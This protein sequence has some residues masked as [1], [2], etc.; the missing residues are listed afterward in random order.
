M[1]SSAITQRHADSCNP[2]K[3]DA[4]CRLALPLLCIQKD[5][6]SVESAFPVVTSTTPTLTANDIV[7]D[8]W[9]AGNVA[10]TVPVAGFV[11][12]SLALANARCEKEVGPGWRMAEFH[13]GAGEQGCWSFVAKRSA[14][15]HSPASLG[16]YQRPT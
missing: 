3:G 5:G 6:S 4:S 12:G 16:S 7:T 9:A 8:G 15:K 14:A 2:H 1:A 10:S 13:D 11:I